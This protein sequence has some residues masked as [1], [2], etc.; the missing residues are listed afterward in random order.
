M[1]QDEHRAFDLEAWE[2]RIQDHPEDPGRRNVLQSQP[3]V[4]DSGFPPVPYDAMEQPCHA[5]KGSGWHREPLLD[6]LIRMTPTFTAT[7]G[8]TVVSYFILFIVIGAR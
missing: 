8:V 7:V 6:Y 4:S 3:R 5:C 2:K 1:S